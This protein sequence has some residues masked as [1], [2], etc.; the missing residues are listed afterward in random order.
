MIK[1][2]YGGDDMTHLRAFELFSTFTVGRDSTDVD[3]KSSRPQSSLFLPE[4]F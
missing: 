1:S 3:E 2:A 4:I